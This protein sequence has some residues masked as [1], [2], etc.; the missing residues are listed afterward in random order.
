[1]ATPLLDRPRDRHDS[2]REEVH[3]LR[4]Q[5]RTRYSEVDLL[6]AAMREHIAD[7][8]A[9]RDRLLDEL[10]R[11]RDDARRESAAWLHR[12]LKGAKS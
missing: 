9:E 10:D 3:R 7:L 12:G 2:M 1:M 4:E 5:A 6:V 8:R 11:A